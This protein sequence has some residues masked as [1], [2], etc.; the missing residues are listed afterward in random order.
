MT[1]MMTVVVHLFIVCDFTR[2]LVLCNFTDSNMPGKR[3]VMP[4]RV[5]AKSLS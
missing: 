5:M 3:S 4:I 1:I 2:M